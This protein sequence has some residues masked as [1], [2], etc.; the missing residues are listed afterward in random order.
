MAKELAHAGHRPWWSGKVRTRCG[1]VLEQPKR[2]RSPTPTQQCPACAA[3][4][5]RRGR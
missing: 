1:L 3:A 4:Q 5:A 2:K